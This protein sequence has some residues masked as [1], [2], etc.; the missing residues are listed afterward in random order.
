MA[1][2]ASANDFAAG[3]APETMLAAVDNANGAPTVR[4]DVVRR[5]LRRLQTREFMSQ[6]EH[7]INCWCNTDSGP[8]DRAWH[9]GTPTIADLSCSLSLRGTSGE[10]AGERGSFHRI[11][12][13]FALPGP[14]PTSPSW[15]EGSARHGAKTWVTKR[16]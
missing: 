11:V 1:T 5:N 3:S 10:R 15:G 13:L 6:M 4:M 2:F 9:L 12:A 8:Q 16:A 7:P 14:L